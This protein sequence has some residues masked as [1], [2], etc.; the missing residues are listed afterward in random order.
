MYRY[1][2]KNRMVRLEKEHTE[3]ILTEIINTEEK[4]RNRIAKDL[5]DGIVQDITSLKF[6]LNAIQ[7]EAPTK[8]H[9]SLSQ[10]NEEID[11]ISSEVR[12]LSYQMM[13]ITLKELGLL[14]ALEEMMNRNLNHNKIDFEFNAL[15]FSD[16]RLPEKIEVTVYRICQELINNTLKHSSATSVS[17]LVQLHQNMLQLTFED[18][19][20]G[21][22][23]ENVKK[24]IGLDS[25][26]SRIAWIK[27]SLE[28]DSSEITKGTTAFIRIPL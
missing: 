17:L 20:V 16:E 23:V 19:G 26:T 14:K 6:M 25:L 11:K 12:E 5:H 21:F 10:L 18:D 22:D 13:P 27:G 4:E 15:G 28:F 9:P 1:I 2:Q 24:G 3:A 7:A 8:L